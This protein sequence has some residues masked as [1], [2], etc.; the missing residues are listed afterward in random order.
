MDWDAPAAIVPVHTTLPVDAA[1]AMTQH[2][3]EAAMATV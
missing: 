3:A 2:D 1:V